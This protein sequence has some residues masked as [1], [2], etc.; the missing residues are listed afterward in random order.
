MVRGALVTSAARVGDGGRV[1]WVG[2][3]ML[4][5]RG[6]PRLWSWDGIAAGSYQQRNTMVM[7]LAVL[8]V[9]VP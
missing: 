1:G 8:A 4:R 6:S 9:G 2:K 7:L 5:R 3:M